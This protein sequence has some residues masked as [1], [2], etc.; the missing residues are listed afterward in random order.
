MIKIKQILHGIKQ[1]T[2]LLLRRNLTTDFIA[3]RRMSEC[4][5][6]QYKIDVLS[7]FCR[8]EACGCILEAKIAMADESCPME[9]W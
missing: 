2:L 8:C 7:L 1:I 5:A 3:D 4:D 6:C 9:R